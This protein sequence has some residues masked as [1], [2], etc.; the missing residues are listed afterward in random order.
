MF[1]WR[2]RIGLLVPSVNT[3]VE[4]EGLD[5]LPYGFAVYATRMRN[6]RSDADDMAQMCAHVDRGVDE[7]LSAKVDV[8]A[9]ACTAGSFFEGAGGEEALRDRL[10][11]GSQIEAVTTAGAVAGALRALD[12]Q[13]VAMVTPYIPELNN[14]EVKFLQDWGFDVV[15]QAGMSI[16]TAFDI[17]V[18]PLEETYRFAREHVGEG[19]DALFI[20]CTNLRTMDVI[21]ALEDDLGIPVVT[22]N[23]ATYWQ[24]L[25]ALGHT[26]SI[27]GYGRL[28]ELSPSTRPLPVTV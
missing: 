26:A 23:Q 13:R 25:R 27:S 24:C 14:L 17:G 22:S 4:P 1:G 18:V 6:S 11:G 2:G 19:A 16:L 8:I 28:F 3:V 10:R 15:S 7:L 9:F 20:S 12:A 5:L 21:Q